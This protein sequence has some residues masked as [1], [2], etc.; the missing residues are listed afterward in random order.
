MPDHLLC[1]HLQAYF[2]PELLNRLDEI[3]VFRQLSMRDARTIAQLL[4]AET[5]Q[6]MAARGI[7][8]QVTAPLMRAICQEGYNQVCSLVASYD[9]HISTGTQ[10]GCPQWSIAV[11]LMG[12]GNLSQALV[13]V[14]IMST[15]LRRLSG[16]G[17]SYAAC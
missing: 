5:E 16:S 6:R 4:L 12:L 11:A 2:R 14:L 10:A 15:P 1:G 3:V 17:I 9:Y 7:G 13:L 8:L